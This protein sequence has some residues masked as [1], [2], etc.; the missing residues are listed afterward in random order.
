MPPITLAQSASSAFSVLP[1]IAILIVF[2][3]IAGYAIMV[4]R[5]RLLTPESH[6]PGAR[7]LFEDLERMHAAGDLT[8]EELAAAK[9]SIANKLAGRSDPEP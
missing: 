6:N 9:K 1:R 4:L 2:V 7:S 5:K 8:D 3:L